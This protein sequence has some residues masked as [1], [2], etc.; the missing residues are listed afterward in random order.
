MHISLTLFFK[1]DVSINLL[2]EREKGD[3]NFYRNLW[4]MKWLGVWLNP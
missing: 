4:T 3:L 2:R 1:N